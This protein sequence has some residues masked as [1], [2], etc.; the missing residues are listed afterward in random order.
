MCFTSIDVTDIYPAKIFTST[1]VISEGRDLIFK[2][3]SGS[4]D[5]TSQNYLYLCKD[6]Q[7]FIKRKQ[8][9]CEFDIMFTIQYANVSHS[10]NY[11]C[12]YSAK[13]YPVSEVAMLGVNSFEILVVGKCLSPADRICVE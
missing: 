1:K 4:C 13:D 2:C 3:S 12:V 9:P 11:S 6:G 10:G 8:K 7:G 5:V